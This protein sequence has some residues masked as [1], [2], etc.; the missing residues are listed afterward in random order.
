MAIKRCLLSLV[1]TIGLAACAG[2]S[3]TG[4]SGQQSTWPDPR[5]AD[6]QEDGRDQFGT[7]DYV[8]TFEVDGTTVHA[9]AY[10]RLVGPYGR[11][12]AFWIMSP[13]GMGT[14]TISQGSY[15]FTT[16]VSRELG[17]IGQNQRL[18]HVDMYR[19]VGELNTHSTLGM[20]LGPISY[21]DM[22]R[23]V[24]EYLEKQGQ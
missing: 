1:C 20:T 16:D 2:T 19:V 14:S 17:E 7:Y 21:D 13:E 10:D 11:I 23:I 3:G 12:H 8:E 24:T 15:D 5:V 18:Y 9:Y 6:A 22:K 4:A